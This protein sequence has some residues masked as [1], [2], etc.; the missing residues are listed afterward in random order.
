MEFGAQCQQHPCDAVGGGT[1]HFWGGGSLCQLEACPWLLS[2]AMDDEDV[3]LCHAHRAASIQTYPRAGGHCPHLPRVEVSQ[4]RET[5][6]GSV[7]D[8]RLT[9]LPCLQCSHF[10]V[11]SVLAHIIFRVP[12]PHGPP[13]RFPS[14]AHLAAEFTGKKQCQSCQCQL[15][16]VPGQLPRV[17]RPAAMS[18][19]G[20]P[21]HG[22]HNPCVQGGPLGDDTAAFWAPGAAPAAAASPVSPLLLALGL[23]VQSHSVEGGR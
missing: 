8:C 11:T 4:H 16:Q 22:E 7:Q 6:R 1:T 23:L 9:V 13:G 5:G 17:P 14:P 2:T 15:C 21:S 12:R 19:W 20:H 10:M 18:L 3:L